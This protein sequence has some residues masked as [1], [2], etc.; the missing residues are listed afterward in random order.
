MSWAVWINGQPAADAT[1]IALAAAA[2]LRSRGESVVVLHHDRVQ[3]AVAG[4][5]P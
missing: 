3:S 5:R 4:T 1:A 2:R